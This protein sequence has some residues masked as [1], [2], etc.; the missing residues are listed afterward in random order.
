MNKPPK[1]GF[2][3]FSAYLELVKNP[4]LLKR[5]LFIKFTYAISIT[6][7]VI[8]YFEVVYLALE[9]IVLILLLLGI[10]YLFNKLRNNA[11]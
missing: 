9:I 3:H 1:K 6:L 8:F 4:Q 2:C 7:N 11:I 5:K 10:G